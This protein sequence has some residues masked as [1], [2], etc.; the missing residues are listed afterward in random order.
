MDPIINAFD[1][2][3]ASEWAGIAAMTSGIKEG[4]L[5]EKYL[6][7]LDDNDITY[8]FEGDRDG[9]YIS[10]YVCD[11]DF[12]RSKLFPNGDPLENNEYGSYGDDYQINFYAEYYP[13][14]HEIALQVCVDWYENE[15]REILKPE[16]DGAANVSDGYIKLSDEDKAAL[17]MA[18]EDYAKEELDRFNELETEEEQE[19]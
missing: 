2:M 9:H 11:N 13:H 14:T 3:S 18:V 7:S 1:G 6:N 10:V 15:I 5:F 17:K 8:E 19:R 16:F 4:G 12:I